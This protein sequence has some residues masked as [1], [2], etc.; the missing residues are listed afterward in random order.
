V[1]RVVSKTH[2]M[3]VELEVKL[4]SAKVGIFYIP[5]QFWVYRQIMYVKSLL[6]TCFLIEKPMW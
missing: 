2:P 3:H 5:F 4:D 1:Q 6:L